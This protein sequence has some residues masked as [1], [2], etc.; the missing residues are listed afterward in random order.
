MEKCRAGNTE[1]HWSAMCD[2]KVNQSK[3]LPIKLAQELPPNAQKLKKCL[4]YLLLELSKF[5]LQLFD[6]GEI[7]CC[8]FGG[9]EG[10]EG[11][12]SVW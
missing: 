12:E 2:G 6:D 1:E 8:R 10:V 9:G 3:L 11:G 5:W 7:F 4:E